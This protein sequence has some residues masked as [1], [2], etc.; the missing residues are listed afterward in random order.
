MK[1]V[2]IAGLVLLAVGATAFFLLRPSADTVSYKREV[3]KRGNIEISISSTGTIKPEN[4]LEI[5][6]PIAG[7]IEEILKR[8]GETV[9]RGDILA[10][11]SST[12]RAALLDAARSKGAKELKYWEELY[13]PTAVVSPIDGTII[14]RNVEAG[15]TFTNA[16]AIYVLSNRLTVK[17]QVDET[18]IAS[19]KIGQSATII[20]DAYSREK[21]I[22]KVTAIAYDS[23]AVNNITTYDVDVTPE[24]APDF[25]RSG[26]TATINF[27]IEQKENILVVTNSAIVEEGG[28]RGVL[29]PLQDD[30]RKF[31]SVEFGI[32]DG[33]NTEVISGLNENQSILILDMGAMSK[34]G[35]GSPLNPRGSRRR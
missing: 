27:M 31:S 13:R 8:E 29:V 22:G 18:D 11:M 30:K 4:R 19:V 20:L 32:S 9:K 24:T 26:M 34:S 1:K 33:K 6:A 7:R 5:K 25:M 12:E 28:E 3:V 21:I 23:T 17:A 14:L 2:V 35:S 16:D 10:W 15:Q